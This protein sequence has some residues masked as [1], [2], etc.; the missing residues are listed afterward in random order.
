[1]ISKIIIGKIKNRRL[2]LSLSQA[3]VAES[4]NMSSS[5]YAK[6]ERGETKLDIE[7]L[8]TLATFYKIT[9]WE[10]LPRVNEI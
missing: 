6:L 1:M 7:R 5:S 10:L 2:N 4:I 8:Y 3:E 9:M